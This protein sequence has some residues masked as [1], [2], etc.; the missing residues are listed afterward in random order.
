MELTVKVGTETVG[1]FC[2]QSSIQGEVVTLC[3]RGIT[4]TLV[5]SCSR[6][7]LPLQAAGQS[8]T[9]RLLLKKRKHQSSFVSSFFCVLFHLSASSFKDASHTCRTRTV[10]FFYKIEY[11][12]FLLSRWFIEYQTYVSCSQSSLPGYCLPM[13][14]LMVKNPENRLKILRYNNR[15]SAESLQILNLYLDQAVQLSKFCI[16]VDGKTGRKS[17]LVVR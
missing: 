12:I 2:R 10:E 4:C 5:T 16:C 7:H 3:Q 15:T 17:L 6:K 11:Y 1:Q 14:N 9:I 13:R 8:F